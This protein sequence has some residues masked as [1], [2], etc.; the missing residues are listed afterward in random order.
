VRRR[1]SRAPETRRPAP[2]QRIADSSVPLGHGAFLLSRQRVLGDLGHRYGR[3][4]TVGRPGCGHV[5]AAAV[6]ARSGVSRSRSDAWL[7]RSSIQSRRPGSCSTAGSAANSCLACAPSRSPDPQVDRSVLLQVGDLPAA[8]KEGGLVAVPGAPFA[9]VPDGEHDIDGRVP[10]AARVHA[11]ARHS[12]QPRE[13][14]D[15]HP[16]DDFPPIAT[17]NAGTAVMRGWQVSRNGREV[18]AEPGV[19]SRDEGIEAWHASALT[20]SSRMRGF[21]SYR[22]SVTL[23]GRSRGSGR[24]IS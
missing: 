15:R 3:R 21:L 7:G 2:Q 19:Q 8:R 13:E 9:R 17:D 12:K 1:S 4:P 14:A 22:A 23:S 18:G 5:L 6:M 16:S 11:H 10:E 20:R 24:Q